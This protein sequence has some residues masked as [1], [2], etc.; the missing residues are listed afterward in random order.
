MSMTGFHNHSSIL[1]D[2]QANGRVRSLI[3]LLRMAGLAYSG[4]TAADT[5]FF[6][7]L[8]GRPW[9]YGKRLWDFK[10]CGLQHVDMVVN[11]ICG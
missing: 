2:L 7:S 8:I 3:P 10:H 11:E 4:I 5:N 1:L 6:T 9:A